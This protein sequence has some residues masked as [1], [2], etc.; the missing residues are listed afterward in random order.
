MTDVNVINKET[1]R[2]KTVKLDLRRYP[3]L[4]VGD[5]VNLYNGERLQTELHTVIAIFKK[6]RFSQ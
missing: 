4:K 2:I 1:R 5:I 3:K 6:G